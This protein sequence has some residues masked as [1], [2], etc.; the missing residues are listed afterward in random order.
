MAT[1][2]NVFE[3]TDVMKSVTI[4]TPL[5]IMT[6]VLKNTLQIFSLFV[7]IATIQSCS[8]NEFENSNRI[9]D[10]SNEIDL[11]LLPDLEDNSKLKWFVSTT[12]SRYCDE[13][14][15]ETQLITKDT[16][17]NLLIK[18][19]IT[20]SNCIGLSSQL[21]AVESFSA[22]DAHQVDLEFA[23]NLSSN[24]SI[25]KVENIYKINHD[26][27]DYFSFDQ[28]EL[29]IPENT[30]LWMGIENLDETSLLELKELF[31]LTFQS[32][33]PAAIEDG[34]YGYVNKGKEIEF[35]LNPLTLEKYETFISVQVSSEIDYNEL[36]SEMIQFS[37]NLKEILPTLDFF[38]STSRGDT[39]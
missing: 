16:D 13:A 21:I 34:D 28:T 27:V 30:L 19:I 8:F 9:I 22:R 3:F 37:S 6:N 36:V 24:I 33:Q 26:Q 5:Y 12:E 31:D 10:I 4:T 25:E 11:L 29:I 15:I 7:L 39:F 14:F 38:I 35:A 17:Q 32:F 18:G 20:P 1:S 23:E 2:N